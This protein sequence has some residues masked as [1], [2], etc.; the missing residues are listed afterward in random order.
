MDR[1]FYLQLAEHGLRMPIGTDLVL[2]EKED[3]PEI[4]VD[5]YRLG[6]VVEEA[7]RRY[8]TPLAVP[9][10]D[11]MIEK[12]A[13]LEL[14]DVPAEQ[15]P[16]Y[17]FSEPPS[18][19]MVETVQRNLHEAP[20]NVRIQAQAGSV[21]YIAQHTD[22]LPI[23]MTIGPFSLMTKLIADPIAP[24]YLAGMG[25]TGE[26]DPEVK[27]V[28]TTLELST[29]VILRSMQAQIEAGA[30]AV[31]VAEPAANKVYI[32]PKQ[33]EQGSGIFEQMVMRY[34]RRVK[35]FLDERGVDLIFHCCGELTDQMVQQYA[36]LEPVI[37]SLGSSRV[38]WE[39]ARLVPKHVVLYGN[40]P[41]KRFYSDELVTRE[42]VELLACEL[43]ARMREVGHPFILGS[44]C[45]V[46]SV[47]GCE[48]T[49]RAKV[50]AFI[51]CKC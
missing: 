40:L 4:L 13:L 2:H 35:A 32:S 16:T 39:D 51:D 38:L 37:L 46:L 14:L 41:S 5:G 8:R 50:Q 10:M 6:Q 31:F 25:I 21:A 20:L 36:S 9:H 45:D 49:I 43:I 19:E 48:Q 44:E 47:E 27:M 28:E 7:A 22:L 42:Q 34:L 23:G 33:L 3:V 12:T 30:R 18:A 11:L 17:H 29:M 26:E 1:R 24:I 15:I